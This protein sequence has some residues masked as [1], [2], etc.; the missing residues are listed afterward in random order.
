[1]ATT[2]EAIARLRM[3]FETQGADAA[4]AEMKKLE[5]AETSLGTTSLNLDRAFGNLE[6]R[7]S[8][9]ARATA[10]YERAM[11][12]LNA[13][14]AQNPALAERAAAVQQTVAARY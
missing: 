2:Q 11:K 12:T 7:Y 13:A 14:V 8:E 6:R 10:D 5:T 1:V 3:I 4:V 9:T